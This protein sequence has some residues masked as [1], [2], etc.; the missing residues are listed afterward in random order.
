MRTYV[1]VD[2]S[3]IVANYRAVQSVSPPEAEVIAVIKDDAYGHGAVPVAHALAAAGCGRFAV[4]SVEE[5]AQL[6]AAGI[7]GEIIALGGFFAG[8]EA[9]AAE[10]EVAPAI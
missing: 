8:Q 1:R 3:R 5:A 4:A 6:R 10:I 7:C 2:L 9:E